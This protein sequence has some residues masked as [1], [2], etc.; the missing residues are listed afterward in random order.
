M[1]AAASSVVGLARK[2]GQIGSQFGIRDIFD[3]R[4]T[5]NGAH[6]GARLSSSR[7]FLADDLMSYETSVGK[8]PTD[9]SVYLPESANSSLLLKVSITE[10][11]NCGDPHPLRK[12]L[13]QMVR[14][15]KLPDGSTQET[16][17]T[18]Y[19]SADNP[20]CPGSNNRLEIFANRVKFSCQYFGS[21]GTTSSPF[22]WA[23]WKRP[24][25]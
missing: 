25:P 7:F 16:V 11:N 3:C 10:P 20:I 18:A 2:K 1:D 9:G 6:F 14:A 5:A 17:L 12:T 15:T 13:V 21:E 23:R 4:V 24:L 22:S 8:N 19:E